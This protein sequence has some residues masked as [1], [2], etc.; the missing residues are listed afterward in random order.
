MITALFT[1]ISLSFASTQTFER[2]CFVAGDDDML[3]SKIQ[4]VDTAWTVTHTAYVDETCKE[5]YL[6]FETKS[7][8]KQDRQNIDMTT[9]EVSY[10]STREDVTRALNE[11]AFCEL[12]NWQTNV[13]QIVTGHQCQDF[14]APKK[15]QVIYS[16]FEVNEHNGQTEA[17][18]GAPTLKADGSTPAKRHQDTESQP[19][20]LKH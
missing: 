7:K 16:I 1:L 6:V 20:Y 9:L 5:S 11:I 12:K 8:V 2:P 19:Y 14:A 4:I 18:I 13:R 10:I 3:T 17:F 15:G